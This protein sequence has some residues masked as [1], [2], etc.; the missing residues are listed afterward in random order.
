MTYRASPIKRQRRTGAEM[1]DIRAA[2]LAV[3]EQDQPMTVRQVFYRLVAAGAIEKTEAEYNGTVC[4][5]L[6]EMRLAGD[7]PFDW[8]ADSTRWMRR[9]I[10]HT[11]VASVMEQTARMYRR[12]LWEDQPVYCEVWLE[13]E[14]LA[15]VLL[16]VTAEWD[17]PLLVTRG[18]PSLSFLHSAALGI[19]AHDKPAFIYYF[20]D[21][22]PSGLDIQRNVAERLREFA[23]EA[24]MNINRLAVTPEQIEAW[25]LPLRPT[26]K[27]DTRAKNFRGGSVEVDAIPPN[28]LRSLAAEHI[29]RHID[30]QQLRIT[31]E[32]ERS[33]RALLYG[34]ANHVRELEAVAPDTKQ[35]WMGDQ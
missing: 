29:E 13:K 7:I 32:A 8:I 16:D 20:G 21:H 11:G 27:T 22:D 2:M 5:L 9:P 4:R 3:L 30:E 28:V 19:A 6:T 31:R 18:Y 24:T 17:V 10:T 25:S 14:A 23:P 34:W 12:K 33:E 1:A 35:W 26:K 15:G